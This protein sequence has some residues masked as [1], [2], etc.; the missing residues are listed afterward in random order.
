MTYLLEEDYYNEIK[1]KLEDLHIPFQIQ[2]N[3]LTLNQN[4]SMRMLTDIVVNIQTTDGLAASIQE[5]LYCG[6]VLLAGDWLPYD[7]FL[8]NGVYYCK[9]SLNKLAENLESIIYN[10]SGH[11]QRCL[12]NRMALHK[13][14]SWQAI[15]PR[16]K[17][18]Y[19]EMMKRAY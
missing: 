6:N 3:R 10:Y 11:K 9:T 4:L 7:L 18:M 17:T 14:T 19:E 1:G 16:W 5:H 12:N 2:R 15:A 8:D 13:L